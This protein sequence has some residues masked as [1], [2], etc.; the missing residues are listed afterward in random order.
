[1]RHP[2]FSVKR[3]EYLSRQRALLTENVVRQW[4]KDVR[5]QLIEENVDLAV[6]EDPKRVF[7]LD[8]TA[9]FTNP[10]GEFFFFNIVYLGKDLNV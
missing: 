1:M 3:S 10:Q 2:I 9:L 5:N 6:L 4:F 8:K 7:N